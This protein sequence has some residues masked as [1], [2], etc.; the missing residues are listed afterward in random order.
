MRLCL[1]GPQRCPKCSTVSCQ[2]GP[3]CTNHHKGDKLLG[4][5]LSW[6]C[7]RQCSR[8]TPDSV[9]RY[10]M[11]CCSWDSKGCW[12]WNPGQPV[13]PRRRW[14][15]RGKEMQLGLARN[16]LVQRVQQREKKEISLQLSLWNLPLFFSLF[17]Y[18]CSLFFFPPL[19]LLSPFALSIMKHITPLSVQ[20][21]A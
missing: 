11:W 9:L 20:S 14:P 6:G 7:T 10:H 16:R 15:V 12:R 13:Q 2:L 4:F 5:C 1:C 8:M 18:L 21:S 17:T 3:K 19:S